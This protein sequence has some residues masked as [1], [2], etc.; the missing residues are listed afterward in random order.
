MNDKRGG[1]SGG[2][3]GGRSDGGSGIHLPLS[4]LP[5]GHSADIS[6]SPSGIF[7]VHFLSFKQHSV[8]PS[9]WREAAS[10]VGLTPHPP[11]PQPG[12]KAWTFE[13]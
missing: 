6:L 12:P 1:V 4:L 2:V 11:S 13:Q 8:Q 5:V 9:H 7:S 10:P 3:S